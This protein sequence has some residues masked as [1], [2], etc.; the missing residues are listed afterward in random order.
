VLDWYAY[1]AQR[2]PSEPPTARRLARAR[3]EGDHPL[4]G[5]LVSV[6]A[7]AAG[8]SLVPL[9][10]TA[11]RRELSTLLDLSL[12]GRTD[13]LLEGLAARV[14][15]L[16]LPPIGAC[17]LGALA[18]GAWQTGGRVS[19]HPLRWDTR[20]LD[21]IACLRRLGDARAYL[22]MLGLLGSLGLAGWIGVG[23]VR[24]IGPD[25]AAGIGNG[26]AA[27]ALARESVQ[28]F[29]L[30]LLPVLVAWASVDALGARRAWL[31]RLRMTRE[32]APSSVRSP[33][34]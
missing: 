2:E 22:S 29:A 10:A 34:P 23:V 15:W 13:G 14:L 25:L 4:S 6:A 24:S 16:G 11:L 7:L 33:E 27:L 19:T 18:A 28:R 3:R 17:A 30:L 12:S 31:G 20:R 32:E 26:E 5:A 1:M 21:P 8:L 9:S